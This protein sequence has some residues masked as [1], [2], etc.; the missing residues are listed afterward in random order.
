MV[1][2]DVPQCWICRKNE[3]R[4]GE[5]MIKKSDL[6]SLLG[7]NVQS[8]PFYYSD[9]FRANRIVQSIKSEILMSPVPICAE[10][11]NE[12]TQ[13]H[14]LAWEW[15]SGWLRTNP[16]S[17]RVGDRI[18]PNPIFPYDTRRQM[19]NVHLYFLKLFG[20]MICENRKRYR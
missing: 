8:R 17:F 20:G 6:K 19:L 13:A 2:T 12:R 5:H 4:T 10:C 15:M 7:K 3:A 1:E 18:R 9:A 11:N 14:D 16:Q